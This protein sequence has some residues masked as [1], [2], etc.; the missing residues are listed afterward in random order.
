MEP[1][2]IL[3]RK[4]SIEILGATEEPRSAGHLSDSL[5]IP[6]ATCYRRVS[7][8][9][10]VGLLETCSTDGEDAPG[11]IRYRRTTDVVGVQFAPTT[12]LFAWT[13]ADQAVG[14]DV[15]SRE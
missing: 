11:A 4:Y 8:L 10:S 5:D 2:Q 12:S 1:V 6:V 3:G 7:E 9:A 15:L 13:R 14:D